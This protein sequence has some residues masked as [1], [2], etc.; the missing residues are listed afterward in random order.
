M[1]M[2]AKGSAP[3]SAQR[4][5]RA[6]AERS[7]AAILDA[8]LGEFL[9]NPDVSMSDIARAAGV[10][11]VTL[12]GHFPSREAV[13]DAVFARTIGQAEA[14]LAAEDLDSLP[15]DRALANL[16]HSSW[17]IIDQHR[18]LLV[19]VTR[20]LGPEVLHAHH[21]TPMQRVRQLIERGQAEGVFRTDLPAEWLVTVF[22]SLAHTAGL[23]TDAGRLHPSVV[24]GY[25]QTTLL[26]MLRPPAR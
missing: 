15:A 12:Y 14:V 8:A 1:S 11:R 25:L 26:G 21:E 16:I 6:D 23:E 22:Y 17:R 2:P 4:P 24:S 3:T 7:I 10:G 20:H 5:K 9:V 19:A 18:H 13:L